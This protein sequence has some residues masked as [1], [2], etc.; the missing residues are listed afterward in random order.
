MKKKELYEAPSVE[1]YDL[2]PESNLLDTAS[3][4]GSW[5][6]SIRGGTTWGSSSEDYGMEGPSGTM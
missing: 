1:T 5:D 6:N 4:N 3:P 2:V